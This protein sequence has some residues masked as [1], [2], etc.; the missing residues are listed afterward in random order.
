MDTDIQQKQPIS[1]VPISQSDYRYTSS[2]RALLSVHLPSIWPLLCSMG[3]HEG[4]ETADNSSEIMGNQDNHLLRR[5]AYLGKDERGGKSTP[6]SVN[7]SPGSSRLH[8][9]S[10]EVTLEPSTGAG[11]PGAVG[12]LARSATQT[13]RREDITDSQGGNATLSKGVGLSMTTF[14]ISGETQRSFPSNAGGS[15]ILSGLAE[16]SPD[17]PCSGSPELRA[18]DDTIQGCQGRSGLVATSFSPLEW[19]DS[20][21][22]KAE[23]IYQCQ[24]LRNLMLPA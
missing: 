18:S 23:D 16:G 6:G 8:C 13:A 4:N 2:G 7:V 1:A 5:H 11:I 15:P 24:G 19:Q 20:S 22:G 14:L 17:S 3:I 12:G 21:G 10:G 9:Q